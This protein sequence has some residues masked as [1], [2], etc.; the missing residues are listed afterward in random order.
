M[1]DPS[2]RE[3]LEYVDRRLGAITNVLSK[4]R[5][6]FTSSG[7]DCLAIVSWDTSCGDNEAPH[8]ARPRV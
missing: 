4:Q 6:V 1:I 7:V 3:M 5:Y 2:L 8:S